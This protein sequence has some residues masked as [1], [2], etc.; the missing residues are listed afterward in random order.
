M[1]N[2]PLEIETN[3]HIGS[4]E[5]LVLQLYDAQGGSAG[6]LNIRFSPNPQYLL[7]YCSWS[8]RRFPTNLPSKINKIW[9][10]MLTKKSGVRGLVVHCNNMK[11]LNVKMTAATCNR[12]V[13]NDYWNKNVK[14]IKFTIGDTA[15]DYYRK[16]AGT[17]G[18]VL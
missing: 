1:E 7:Q 6:L 4:E 2:N 12:I 15:S 18:L 8:Y 10:V 3:S 13:W 5:A 16:F 9:R 14:M 17:A 11:V